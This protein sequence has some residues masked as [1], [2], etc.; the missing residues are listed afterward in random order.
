MRSFEGTDELLK[1][2]SEGA[3]GIQRLHLRAAEP[4]EMNTHPDGRRW[5]AGWAPPLEAV[6]RWMTAT[7]SPNLGQRNPPYHDVDICSVS[8]NLSVS[9]GAHEFQ[10]CLSCAVRLFCQAS[11]HAL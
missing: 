9:L 7:L 3:T 10:N 8:V 5:N 6:E 1:K 11:N 4:K 2:A